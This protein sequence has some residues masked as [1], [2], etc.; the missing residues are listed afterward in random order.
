MDPSKNCLYLV[1]KHKKEHA[2]A[3]NFSVSFL[4]SFYRLI[5][6]TSPTILMDVRQWVGFLLLF[7]LFEPFVFDMHCAT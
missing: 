4:S 5:V 7:L 6:F 3:H 1:T 2:Y